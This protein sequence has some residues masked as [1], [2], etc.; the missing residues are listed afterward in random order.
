MLCNGFLQVG[1]VLH[2]LAIDTDDDIIYLD[3]G[4]GSRTSIYD[5]AYPNAIHYAELFALIGQCG[6]RFVDRLIGHHITVTRKRS[7]LD[8]QQRTLYGSVLFQVADHFGHHTGRNGKTVSGISACGRR[9]HGIDTYQFTFCIHQ[10]STA[11]SLIDGGICLDE[12]FY[13]P[14]AVHTE[15]TCLGTDDTG[16]YS[17]G[18][19]ERVTYRQYPLSYFQGIRIAHGDG[20][21]IVSLDLDQSQI[22]I[23]VGTDHATFELAVVIQLNDNFVRTVD[24]VIIGDDVTVFGND[25]TGTEA[26]TRLGLYTA[27]L[28]ATITEDI[29][30]YLCK[31]V[32][33]GHSLFFSLLSRFYMY[34]SM[35]RIF[36]RLR[37][38]Y[39]LGINGVISSQASTGILTELFIKRQAVSVLRLQHR[40]GCHSGNSCTEKNYCSYPENVFC[41]LFHTILFIHLIVNILLSFNIYDVK[42]TTK[43][44]LL[45]SLSLFFVLF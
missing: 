15:R 42:I 1:K 28:S 7:T 20:R 22:R 2:F 24:H 41:C 16:S 36:R 37:Q 39:R 18:K 17:R 13:S 29:P 10:S 12:R 14:D 6:S 3:I 31:R 40:I 5:F 38:I 27:L 23:R 35:K 45:F 8:T 30:E 19:I 9:K 33:Y 4:T 21:E 32:A 11:V 25:D 26:D 34:Y 44:I 43:I